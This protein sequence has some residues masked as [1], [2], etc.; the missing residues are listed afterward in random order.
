MVRSKLPPQPPS[1]RFR[2]DS[3]ELKNHRDVSERCRC[4]LGSR[5][6]IRA[7]ILCFRHDFRA[8]SLTLGLAFPGK[9]Q[10]SQR[11]SFPRHPYRWP[12]TVQISAERAAFLDKT[13]QFPAVV[14]KRLAGMA[15]FAGNCF[16]RIRDFFF[17]ISEFKTPL[18]GI[19]FPAVLNWQ[20][21]P[22]PRRIC[23]FLRRNEGR[24]VRHRL[25]KCREL[26]SSRRQGRRLW[27]RRIP[28]DNEYGLRRYSS[29]ARRR[30]SENVS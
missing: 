7:L 15:K 24:S 12:D 10:T 25:G 17:D 29:G 21:E 2:D 14:R 28:I 5:D 16:S 6:G 26:P 30:L 9:S 1:H 4:C 22:A 8:Q 18:Q 13:P 19:A 3:G 11:L 20:L 23:L 27:H